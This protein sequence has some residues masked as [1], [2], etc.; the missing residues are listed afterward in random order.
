MLTSFGQFL[1]FLEKREFL[2]FGSLFE[3]VG[4]AF[5]RGPESFGAIVASLAFVSS[6]YLAPVSIP[7]EFNF[8]WGAGKFRQAKTSSFADATV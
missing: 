5:A 2:D 6:V 1:K 3:I 4:F 7:P 8:A